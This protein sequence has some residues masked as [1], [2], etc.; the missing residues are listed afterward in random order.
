MLLKT[1]PRQRAALCDVLASIRLQEQLDR[2]RLAQL[3]ELA[4]FAICVSAAT[5]S[6]TSDLSVPP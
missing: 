3:G 6:H 2:Q 1:G 4:S 5:V